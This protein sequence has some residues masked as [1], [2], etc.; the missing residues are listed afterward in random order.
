M[1]IFKDTVLSTWEIGVIKIA[2][3]CMAVAIGS[4]WPEV[5]APYAKVLFAIGALA[6]VYALFFWTKK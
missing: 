2:V 3:A 5:F 1:K 6:S 4:I